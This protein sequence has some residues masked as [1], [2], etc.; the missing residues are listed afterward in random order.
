MLKEYSKEQIKKLF[1]NLPEELQEASMSFENTELIEVACKHGELD[2]EKTEKVIEFVGF[3]FLG[4][5]PP[6]EFKNSLVKELDVKKTT[7]EKIYQEIYRTVFFPV[8]YQLFQ[9][10]E[11]GKI[12]GEIQKNSFST[13]TEFEEEEENFEKPKLKIQESP[14][15]EEFEEKPAVESEKKPVLEEKQEK[16]ERPIKS[17]TYM[18]LIE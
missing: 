10:Y 8:K 9:L 17:D 1:I 3:V 7:A 6:E 13:K 16:I 12:A 14:E 15:Q 11:H 5:L 18:E 4:L 2:S